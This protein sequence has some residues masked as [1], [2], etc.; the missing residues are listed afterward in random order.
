MQRSRKRSD[1]HAFVRALAPALRQSASILRAL[2][3][4]VA[5]RPK[6]GERSA[7]KAAL[8]IA[9]TASQ[10]ALL[11]P[12][13][14]HFP[15]VRLAAEEDT[16]TAGRFATSGP[17]LVVI[18]P[19][20]GTLRFYL[21]GRGAYA[22]MIALAREAACQAALVALPREELYFDA[23]RGSGARIARRDG[24]PRAARAEATGRR[25]LVSIEVPEA[26][27]ECL[28]RRGYQPE[29]ASGGAIAVAPLVPG[30]CAG[31]RVSPPPDA[32]I[33]VRGRIGTLIAAEAG[34]LVRGRKGEPFPLDLEAPGDVLLVAA[35]AEQMRDLEAA[36]AAAGIG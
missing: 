20:D 14:E 5:N 13:Y 10:E 12:L 3:G 35:G 11:V 31:L 29:E 2:E 4:R 36:L 18:D 6:R 8:T 17:E 27:R 32:R 15:G 34:A 25:V 30:A 1:P 7:V 22:V 24:A 19:L 33:S 26:A 9:D 28:L 16:P 23:V 21:E